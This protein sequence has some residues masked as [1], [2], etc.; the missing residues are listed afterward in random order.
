MDLSDAE[1]TAAAIQ[2]ADPDLVMHLAA[3]S[4]GDR[5]IEGPGAYGSTS[6][7]DCVSIPSHLSGTLHLLQ[8]VRGHWEKHPAE[9]Q[10]H[11]RVHV[12]VVKP[13]ADDTAMPR[14]AWLSPRTR[15]QATR[16][17]YPPHLACR[18]PPRFAQF[19]QAPSRPA[20]TAAPMQAVA[21][22]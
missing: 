13:D 19:R 17:R 10:H 3:E 11:V 12:D 9:H 14:S 22:M 16:A 4:H 2:T 21:L 18:S 5:S 20:R 6:S 7:P 8:A 1:A 15:S